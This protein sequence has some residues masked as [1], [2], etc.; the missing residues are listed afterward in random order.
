MK[1]RLIILII[2][3]VCLVIF[4]RSRD[5]AS[6]PPQSAIVTPPEKAAKPVLS[7]EDRAKIITNATTD[8]KL[9]R[10]K[11]ERTSFYGDKNRNLYST[12]FGAYLSIPDDGRAWLRVRPV[13]YSESWVFFKRIKVMADDEVVYEKETPSPVHDN[14]GGKVWETADYSAEEKDIAALR[15]IASSKKVTVR[16]S[17]RDHYD[18]HQMSATELANL[19]KILGAYDAL[20]SL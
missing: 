11:M 10:D 3:A 16:F 2:A 7:S 20:Q 1:S 17:G 5:G 9:K 12:N 15:K 13:Y 19:R 6:P 14:S 8:L 4:T 18:D